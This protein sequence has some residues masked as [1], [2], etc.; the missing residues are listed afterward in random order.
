MVDN[1]RPHSMGLFK[2]THDFQFGLLRKF[3]YNG[4]RKHS[5]TLTLI[6]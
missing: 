6:Q 2:V 4:E 3:G 1:I 5:H